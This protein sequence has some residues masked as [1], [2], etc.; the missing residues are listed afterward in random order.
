M[1]QT[2]REQEAPATGGEPTTAQ[3]KE[4]VQETAGQVQQQVGQKVDEVRG[5]AGESVRQQLDTRSTQAGEQVSAAADALRRVGSQLRDE[6][7]ETP[8]KVAEGAAEPVQRLGKYLT[9]ADGQR[10]LRDAEQFARRRPWMTAMGG[11]VVGFLAA[12]FVKASSTGGGQRQGTMD[13]QQALPQGS[14]GG[15]SGT[16]GYAGQ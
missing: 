5:Q 10:I 9:D 8:A 13:R 7:K 16:H 12:R 4:K 6:G 3:A 11:A 2:A 15:S 1:T 14:A